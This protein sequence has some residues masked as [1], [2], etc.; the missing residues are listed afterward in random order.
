MFL[1]SDT[2]LIPLFKIVLR[3]MRLVIMVSLEG[4]IHITSTSSGKSIIKLN[5]G[6]LVKN[7]VFRWEVF[8]LAC[9]VPDLGPRFKKIKAA[10]SISYKPTYLHTSNLD[11]YMPR[12]AMALTRKLVLHQLHSVLPEVLW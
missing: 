12:G 5:L 2:F 3:L 4:H 6:G 8:D 10:L 1:D 9:D 11:S 7:V